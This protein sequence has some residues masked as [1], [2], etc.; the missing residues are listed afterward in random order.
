MNT[1]SK[2]TIASTLERQSRRNL[3]D[4]TDP[5]AESQPDLFKLFNKIITQQGNNSPSNED[6]GNTACHQN[7]ESP[8][9][10]PSRKQRKSSR[11]SYFMSQTEKYL[12]APNIHRESNPV[13]WWKANQDNYKVIILNNY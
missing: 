10:R 5:E 2:Q 3:G 12:S 1:S 6:T 4:S 13:E 9:E 8:V 7:D 11:S